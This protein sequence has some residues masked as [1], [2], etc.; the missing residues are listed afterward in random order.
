MSA[1]PDDWRPNPGPQTRFLSLTCREALFGGRA[2]GGKSS[3]LLADATRYIG[4][5]YGSNYS[6]L[7]LRRTFPD[8]E[9]SLIEKSLALY[10][11]FG[12]KYNSQKKQWRFP[13][14]ESIWF[15]HLEHE[16]DIIQYQ[17]AEFQF[18][19]FDE[20]THFSESQYLYLFSRLRSSVGIP[21]RMRAGT[22]PG[23]DGHEWVFK[24]FGYWLD[25]ERPIK[26]KPGEVIYIITSEDGVETVVPK[27]TPDAVSRCFVPAGLS[28]NPYID[29]DGEYRRNLQQLDRVTRERLRDGNWLIKPAR[30][31][32]FKRSYFRIVDV[33]PADCHWIRYWDRASSGETEAVKRKKK[34]PDYTVGLKLGKTPSGLYVVGHVERFR[35][36]P[37]GVQDKV[38]TIASQDGKR[39]AIG[40]EQDPAQ[41][42]EAE[43][44]AYVR[45]LDG[46]NVRRFPARVDKVTRAQPVSAQAEAGNVVIVRGP[47]NDSLLNE[48]EAFPESAHDDQVDALSGAHNALNTVSFAQGSVV[49]PFESVLDGE[50]SGW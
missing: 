7:L 31:L 15:G 21:L 17:S 28:D 2:G 45:M 5:G 38:K 34:D 14:G 40:I 29:A 37:F 12:A 18:I 26:A 25:P 42:G 24:R 19:G 3:G 6:A 8:L 48:L 47:W 9:K 36:S 11:R 1:H 27:G 20:L 43:S 50:D 16:K 32:Y 30:G 35:E 46:Y 4:R 44:L 10:P 22:N 33:A 39:C 49:V 41:A 23:G 13:G